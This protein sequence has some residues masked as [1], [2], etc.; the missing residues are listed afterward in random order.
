MKVHARFHVADELRRAGIVTADAEARWIVEAADRGVGEMGDLVA[1]RSAGEPLQYVTGLAG[2]RR[3][4]IEVGP[5]VFIPR[6]ETE[7]VAGAAIARLPKDGVAVDLCTGS[8]AI[9]FAIADERPD[10]EV[11]A[12]EHSSE[13]L[14]W[15]ARNR[16]RL[17]LAV[18]LLQGDLFRPL[19]MSMAGRV[20]V[21][22]SNPPYVA[23]EELAALPL[24]VVG[25]EPSL[26]LFAPRAGLAVIE[27]I[28]G[29]A[30]HWLAPWG[31]LVLEIGETQGP[32]VETLLRGSGYEAVEIGEDLTG[33]DRVAIGR[34][35][36]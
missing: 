4:E 21:V 3:L 35:P 30:L 1:R 11:W 6:P 17:G 22:V 15:A 19:P 2:F 8:G 12:T 26:A 36:V 31:W 16:Q 20:D 7:I 34:L 25:Y 23:F 33:R 9:A 29:Q 13:A 18:E 5:G 32:T 27:S 28:A 24:E 10:I 14:A